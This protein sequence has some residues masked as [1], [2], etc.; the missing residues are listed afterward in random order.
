MDLSYQYS[1]IRKHEFAK[2][3]KNLEVNGNEWY[4]EDNMIA[5]TRNNFVSGID[6]VN[7]M[8]NSG[9]NIQT[10]LE[11]ET[12]LNKGV[13]LSSHN[14]QILNEHDIFHLPSQLTLSHCPTS[15]SNF[16]RFS[17]P[18]SMHDNEIG[19]RFPTSR[20]VSLL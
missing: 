7:S 20:I 15:L 12:N 4:Q 17:H 13:D 2:S 10:Q 1:N 18:V 19:L 5:A 16:P 11:H 14:S 9:K 3:Q 8:L 6:N